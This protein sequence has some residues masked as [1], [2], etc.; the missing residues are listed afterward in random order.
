MAHAMAVSAWE[1]GA[2]SVSGLM[3]WLV[4]DG[5]LHAGLF[6]KAPLA[7][8]VDGVVVRCFVIG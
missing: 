5:R 6:C 2:V 1:V 4:A 8:E 3:A 7:I